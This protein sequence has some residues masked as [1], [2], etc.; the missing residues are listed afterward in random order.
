MSFLRRIKNLFSRTR[1]NAEIEEELRAHLE[2]RT[3]H[4]LQWGMSERDARRDALVRFGNLTAT[5]ERVASADAALVLESIWADVRYACRGLVKNPGFAVTAMLV[6]ALGV[7]VSVAIFAFADAVLIRP[8]PYPDPTRLVMLYESLSLGPRYHMSYLDSVDWRRDNKTLSALEV[9][10]GSTVVLST[11]TGLEQANGALVSPGFLHMLGATPMMGRDFHAG[12]DAMGAP[13]VVLIS[14]GSW[15]TRFGGRREV[16]G[17]TVVLDGKE[18]MIVGVLPQEFY[19]SPIGAAEFWSPLTVQTAP[20]SRGEHGLTGLGR[21]KDGVAPETAAADLG[22]IAKRLSEQ[23]PDCDGGRGATVMPFSEAVVGKVRSLLLLLLSGAALLLLIACVNVASLLLVRTESRQREFALR[24][25]LGASRGRVLRQVVIEAV[26]LVLVGSAAGVAA[27]YGF[28]R[29][30]LPLIPLNVQVEMPYLHGVG[31]SAHVLW[32]TAAVA[33]G[34]ACVLSLTPLARISVGSVRTGLA[35]GGRSAAGTVWRHLGANLVVLELCT[36][37]VLLVGAGLLGKS[38]Y[39]L[40]H[41]EI[42]MEPDHLSM[43]RINVSRVGFRKDAETAAVT[44]RVVSEAGRLPG[45]TAVATAQLVPVSGGFWGSTTFEIIGRPSH[46]TKE[47]TTRQV[48]ANYFSVIEARLLQGR[49]FRENEDGTKPLVTIVNQTFAHQYFPGE[50]VVGKVLRT[51]S[52]QPPIEIVGVVEDI[53]EGALDEGIRPVLYL[54]MTQSPPSLFFI[55]ARTTR[56]P[57]TLLPELRAAAQ[58]VDRGIITLDALSMGYRIHHSAAAYLHLSSAWLASGFAVMALLLGVVG[59]YGVVAYSV[60]QRTREIGVRMALGAQKGTVYWMI[61]KEAGRLV[62]VGI[63]AGW[64]CAI[65]AAS[66][67]GKMLYGTAPWDAGTLVSVAVVLGGAA[68]IA[69]YLPARRAASVNPVEA[70]RAE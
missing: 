33:F 45:V 57:E 2:M 60:S 25:A 16:L 18:S 66:L 54:P 8:L 46:E 32:F 48:S 59:L 23:Y 39:R 53:R 29:L 12:E 58:G 24:G 38:F 19:F 15:K 37:M 17:E 20:D 9:F 34:M 44:R 26:T 13:G 50:E 42:G 62:G 27:S 10:D 11:P 69:S 51:D 49:Y 70:L 40:L 7:G 3:E 43:L 61:L 1:L 22:A 41:T 64:V 56:D 68:M 5:K 47:A 52:S 63:V 55:V 36:A 65:G 28:V 14:Y 6:L 21:L 30:L 35:E 4:N 67:M 31:L